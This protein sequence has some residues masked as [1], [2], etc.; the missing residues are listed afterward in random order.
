MYS[1][2][3]HVRD[4]VLMHMHDWSTPK[5]LNEQHESTLFLPLDFNLIC[6]GAVGGVLAVLILLMTVT[7]T[8]TTVHLLRSQ[9]KRGIILYRNLECFGG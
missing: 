5:Q 7:V 8:V 2:L 1:F 4:S 6:T 3:P 9:I